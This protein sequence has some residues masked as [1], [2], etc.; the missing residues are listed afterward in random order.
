MSMSLNSQYSVQLLLLH[1]ETV[2]WNASCVAAVNICCFQQLLKLLAHIDKVWGNK[3]IAHELLD[4][5]VV[6]N[7]YLCLLSQMTSQNSI[8]LSK[9]EIED[10][11]HVDGVKLP[12]P[13]MPHWKLKPLREKN[14]QL[15]E[16][17]LVS[18]EHHLQNS[19]SSI[20]PC[21]RQMSCSGMLTFIYIVLCCHACVL[22][23]WLMAWHELVLSCVTK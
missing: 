12:D 8:D 4:V 11:L 15:I 22:P 18:L 6:Y 17:Y 16:Q 3:L 23:A 13:D 20:F 2:S 19:L 9:V 1:W 5:L 7:A 10:Y 21:N 14:L